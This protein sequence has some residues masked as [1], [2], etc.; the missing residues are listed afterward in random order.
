MRTVPTCILG[1]A[2]ENPIVTGAHDPDKYVEVGSF[3]KVITGTILQ[4]LAGQGV[5]TPDDPVERWLGAP[6][7]TGI[8]LRH[9]AEHTSGLPRLPPGTSRRDP[10]RTFTDDRLRE[11]LAGLDLLTVAPA[12]QRQEYSNLGYAVLGAALAAASGQEYEELVAGLVLSPLGLPPHAMSATP[13]QHSRLLPTRWFGRT[14][15]PWTMTG[16][17][18]PAGGLWATPRT[19]ARVLTAL[20]LDRSLGDPGLG[21]QRTGPLPVVW[22]NGATGTASVFAGAVPDGRWTVVHRLSGDSDVT[23]HAGLDY[24][25]TA[26][27]QPKE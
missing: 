25:R 20:V 3:T 5:L 10:Y 22:H 13:P 16:A 24:L 9:L 11:L 21:W 2:D 23:D 8:T 7:G 27:A 19:L 14:V 18:L 26:Q 12:G 15:K 17:V 4:Q 1:S 6:P